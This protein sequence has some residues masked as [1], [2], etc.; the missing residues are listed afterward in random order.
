MLNTLNIIKHLN[1]IVNH[2]ANLYLISHVERE[3]TEDV[4]LLR[5]MRNAEVSFMFLE[6]LPYLRK[7]VQ[8]ISNQMNLELC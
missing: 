5:S 4:A 3:M 6:M 1:D 8:N 2:N 7:E